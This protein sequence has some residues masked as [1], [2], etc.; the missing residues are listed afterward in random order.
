MHQL[1]KK[2]RTVAS[3]VQILL[4]A[5]RGN[6]ENQL[7]ISSSFALSIEYTSGRDNT[8]STCWQHRRHWNN[9]LPFNFTK[10]RNM[11]LFHKSFSIRYVSTI[12][13]QKPHVIMWSI[14]LVRVI[15]SA[16]P[17]HTFRSTIRCQPTTL[18]W[19]GLIGRSPSYVFRC[20][21]SGCGGGWGDFLTASVTQSMLH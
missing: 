18:M 14:I 16:S 12:E 10:L 19:K 15:P 7:T 3:P 13:V 1:F 17:I 21:L 20:Q 6:R 5:T 9:N 4:G 11:Y 8:L 2:E